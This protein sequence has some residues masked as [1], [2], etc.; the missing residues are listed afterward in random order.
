MVVELSAGRVCPGVYLSV[1]LSEVVLAQLVTQSRRLWDDGCQEE[2]KAMTVRADHG[3]A[4]SEGDVPT[5]ELAR[6]KGVRPIA[7]VSELAE[8]EAFE[9][10]A[11]LDEFLNDL[12][13]SRHADLA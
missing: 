9:S 3:E 1:P 5:E 4:W 13:A 2:V 6:R 8:P 7:S 12:Y 10:D 11:E